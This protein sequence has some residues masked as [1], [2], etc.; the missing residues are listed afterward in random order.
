MNGSGM[1][2]AIQRFS[3]HDGPG[4][5][6]TVFLKGCALRCAW[7]HNPET[8]SRHNEVMWH[9]AK[10]TACGTCANV[11]PLGHY[12]GRDQEDTARCLGCG[13]CVAHCPGHALELAGRRLTV[14]NVLSEII[15]DKPFYGAEGG[16]TLSGGEPLLQNQFVKA[17]LTACREQHI[18]T[19]IETSLHYPWP[20]LE[21]LLPL[22]DLLIFDLKIW[23]E[24]RH[25][26]YTGVTNT[27]ILSNIRR[28][29]NVRQPLIARTPL[30]GGINDTVTE[31]AN[32]ARLLATLPTLEHYELLPYHPLGT[33]KYAALG[34]VA[35]PFTTPDRT[36]QLALATEALKHRL[37]V[38]INGQPITTSP[39]TTT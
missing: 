11:C 33:E 36:C 23:D 24:A 26:H 18:H 16:V 17:I 6:T 8:F 27:R 30:I 38:R 1:V 3:L 31:I 12:Q 34:L 37:N 28:L 7:C 20:R 15:E 13:E 35:T 4:I 29:A 5:R 22:I 14:D 21:P 10:C 39:P 2:S 9:Q 19:A 25:R 32:M